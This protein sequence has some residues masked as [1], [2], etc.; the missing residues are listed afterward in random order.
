MIHKNAV[1]LFVF[2]FSREKNTNLYTARR[3]RN[4]VSPLEE[5]HLVST[6]RSKIFVWTFQKLSTGY[7]C[8][9]KLFSHIVYVEN[10]RRV[11]YHGVDPC[12]LLEEHDAEADE[13]TAFCRS[14][15]E[16]FRQQNSVVVGL[17]AGRKHVIETSPSGHRTH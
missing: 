8:R 9:G 7:S 3:V 12:E 4:D 13:Q 6:A 10:G 16:R 15:I 17:Y 2:K 1:L 14:G 5:N 11:E